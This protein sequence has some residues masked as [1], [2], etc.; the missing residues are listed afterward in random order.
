MLAKKP[1]TSII[2]TQTL[3]KRHLMATNVI[4]SKVPNYLTSKESKSF[5]SS[6]SSK[7]SYY[8]SNKAQGISI[9]RDIDHLSNLKVTDAGG[10][11][12]VFVSSSRGIINLGAGND[13]VTIV[14]KAASWFHR[15]TEHYS[16]TINAGPGNDIING[17]P[18]K[19]TI[20]AGPGND[21]IKGDA[22][23][24]TITIGQGND[25][26]DI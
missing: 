24:D 25:I 2:R 22:D 17:G 6:N 3:Q 21:V 10:D 5:S 18:N 1:P 9:L 4:L 8:L 14:Q 13:K 26:D 20:D 12:I 23:D 16:V 11:N 7:L 19:D 15:G